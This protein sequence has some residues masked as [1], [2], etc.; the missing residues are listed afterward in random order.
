[1]AGLA[2][3]GA[4]GLSIVWVGLDASERDFSEAEGWYWQSTFGWV[5]ACTVLWIAYFPMYL[6]ARRKMPLKRD[7]QA[8][9]PCPRCGER[10]PNGV[11]DCE[12]CGFD[13]RTIGASSDTPPF[14][15]TSVGE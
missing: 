13:F 9:R 14:P 6:S 11:L 15:R 3:I 8:S 2:I 5:A 1:M 10:V 4:I 7:V 12:A